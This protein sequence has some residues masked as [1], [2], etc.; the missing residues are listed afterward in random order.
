MK[1][2]NNLQK[3]QDELTTLKVR[4]EELRAEHQAA[5]LALGSARTALVE[6]KG[7]VEALTS[8]QAA[9]TAILGACDELSMRVKVKTL[10]LETAHVAELRAEKLAQLAQIGDE[11]NKCIA[12]LDRVA[13]LSMAELNKNVLEGTA[14]FRLI[15]D[16]HVEFSN[17]KKALG[18][19]VP[20]QLNVNGQTV[21]VLKIESLEISHLL[22]RLEQ[23][24]LNHPFGD[25]YRVAILDSFTRSQL[26]IIGRAAGERA[27]QN[28]S[29]ERAFQEFQHGHKAA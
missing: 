12:E 28:V 11:I 2:A 8:K 19:D 9:E 18:G 10:E 4:Q 24:T 3:L 6:G 14:L 29:D 15:G 27:R 23:E 21:D 16:K 26:A 25:H 5:L 1:T 7:T 22:G 20:E 17:L 13:A